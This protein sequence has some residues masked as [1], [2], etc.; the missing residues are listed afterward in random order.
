MRRFE[1]EARASARLT[2][3]NIGR[4]YDYGV[5]GGE[6]AYL[7][8]ELIEGTTWRKELKRLTAFP[9]DLAVAR[10]DALLSGVEAAHRAG[11]VHRDL[12][13]ENILIGVDEAG[14]A[15]KI[16]DFGL[17]KVI[18]SESEETASMTAPRTV[19]GTLGYMAPEQ[20]MGGTVDERTDI[21]TLG[22]I[23]AEAVT[24]SR[25]FQLATYE[26]ALSAMLS[27]SYRLPGESDAVARLNGV[28]KRSMA[29]DRERRYGSVAQF[30]E[31]LLPALAEFPA[32]P[33][34]GLPD[35]GCDIT[36]SIHSKVFEKGV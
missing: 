30:R 4:I 22:V 29:K 5:L 10:M 6:G 23:A 19:L 18:R 24:G 35:A 8:M 16:V 11:I 9:A 12:K 36:R 27:E 21:F 20:L 3:R 32:L 15:I 26:A 13:P 14:E 34:E 1:N 28:L 33:T 25:P 31:E 2:H 17:A 7:V